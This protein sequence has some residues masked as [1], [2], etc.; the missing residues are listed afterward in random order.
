[1]MPSPTVPDRPRQRRIR[2]LQAMALAHL[3]GGLVLTWAGHAPW[4]DSYFASIEQVFWAQA[5]P[6]AAREQQVWW[7]ALFAATV[8]SYALYM[9]ALIQLGDRFADHRVWG[10]LM[11]GLLLWAPQDLWLSLRVGL[12]SHGVIDGL[13][14]L[15]L[16][17]P[18]VWLYRHDRRQTMAGAS[19]T[20][21]VSRGVDR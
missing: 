2:W 19:P 11:A 7:M 21:G 15:V 18:L 6:V 12:W 10:W 5:V 3:F 17:P 4:F 20:R 13:A 1:M 8:Q 9:L 14:L 16:V